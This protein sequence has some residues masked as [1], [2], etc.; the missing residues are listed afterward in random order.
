MQEL[1]GSNMEPVV[2]DL[3]GANSPLPYLT[4]TDRFSGLQF[5]LS[6]CSQCQLVYLNPRPSL[7]ELGKHYPEDYEAYRLPEEY[8]SSVENWHA[9]RALTMQLNYVEH[10]LPKRGSL[11]DVGCA[12]GNFLNVAREHGW[13]VLG[14]E[15]VEKAAQIAREH[16]RLK[17]ISTD[18]ERADLL[19]GS[20]DAVTLWDV[21][22][23]VPSPKRA[24]CRIHKLLKP[25]GNLYFSI[26]NLDSFDRTLFGAE[27]IGWDV[28][29]HFTLFTQETIQRLLK[30]TGFN[31]V[32]RR[33]LLGG[34]GTFF[35]SLERVFIKYPDASWVRRTYPLLGILL[36]PYRQFAYLL[37]RGPILFYTARKEAI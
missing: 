1:Y 21:L 31:L 18:L 14:L 29:R 15:V 11:L 23:H 8:G 37:K 12:T 3:C 33:C 17:V 26:P 4:T 2:C 7:A 24:L 9:E 35:L 5:N 28:P 27:W 34:K 13:Q 25:G 36:W 19:D 10:Y 30:E 6:V 20:L 32:D 16:Y 22:E